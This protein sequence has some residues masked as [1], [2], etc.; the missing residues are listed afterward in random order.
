MNRRS[1]PLILLSLLCTVAASA[2]PQSLLMRVYPNGGKTLYCQ[3]PFASSSQVRIDFIYSKTDLLEHFSCFTTEMCEKKPEFSRAYNDLH[4]IYPVDLQSLIARGG[5]N[6]AEL[7]SIQP[8][9]PACPI[10]TSYQT[11][12]PPDYAKGNVARAMVYMTE[13]YHLPIRGSLAMYQHWSKLDPPDQEEV[14]RNRTI[15]ALQGLGNP[16]IENPALMDRVKS[17]ESNPFQMN[18]P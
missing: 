17:H 8:K 18:F 1:L 2:D 6:F 14:R 4:N 9:D 11:F 13:T 5:A 7:A 16:Y 15:K 10:R 12:E 3:T